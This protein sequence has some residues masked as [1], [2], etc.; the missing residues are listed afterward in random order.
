MA[1]TE[2]PTFN[3]EDIVGLNT[4]GPHDAYNLSL[5]IACPSQPDT[6]T[7]AWGGW[8]DFGVPCWDLSALGG[9]SQSYAGVEVW[10][11]LNNYP[12]L[13]LPLG[14]PEPLSPNSAPTSLYPANGVVPGEG[15]SYQ[16]LS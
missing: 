13:P 5:N 1:F 4:N 15:R 7:D 8:T 2:F 9:P 14:A 12:D 3:I 6:T 11:D 16:I 10:G